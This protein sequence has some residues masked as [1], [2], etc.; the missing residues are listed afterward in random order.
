[1]TFSV[2]TTLLEWKF[3]T[4]KLIQIKFQFGKPPKESPCDKY[5]TQKNSDFKICIWCLNNEWQEI[6]SRL[7]KNNPV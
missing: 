1:M 7:K 3:N 4:E 5:C 2:H 6:L